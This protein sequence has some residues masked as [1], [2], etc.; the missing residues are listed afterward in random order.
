MGEESGR[1]DIEAVKVPRPADV[2]AETIR[3]KIISGEFPVGTQLPPERQLVEDSGLARSVVRDALGQL[4]RQGLIVVKTGRRGGSI[5]SRPT[6]SAFMSSVALHLEGWAPSTEM[7]VEA[8]RVIEPW[9]A[10]FAAE[11]RTNDDLA[12]L[13]SIND[14][15]V[16][17]F[18]SSRDFVDCKIQWHSAV[19]KAS[20]N[21]V[22]STFIE[23]VS[24]A[25]YRQFDEDTLL[26][27]DA[28]MKHSLSAHTEITNAIANRQPSVA[29]RLMAT[30]LGAPAIGASSDGAGG[31]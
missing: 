14:R 23:A 30:H 5:V 27:D 10:Y 16:E 25:A 22:L 26:G 7:L 3:D 9:C 29:F 15:T 18:E 21:E 8:R 1:L 12:E 6:A 2:F 17:A 31:Q 13:T 19:S 20:H 4:Q 24:R 11:R 28:A